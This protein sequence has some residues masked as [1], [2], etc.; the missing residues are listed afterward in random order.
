MGISTTDRTARLNREGY[1]IAREVVSIALLQHLKSLCLQTPEQ[2]QS[3]RKGTSLYGVRHLLNAVPALHEIVR[4][5]P[6]IELA[7]SVLGESARPVKGIFF[8]KTPTANWLVPWHQDVTITVKKRRD[9]AGFE[10]RPVQGGIVHVLPPVSLSERLLTLRIHLDDAGA[11]HGALRVIPRSHLSGRLSPT[12]IRQWVDRVPEIP[13]SVA[14]GDVM[15][16]RPLLLHASSACLLPGHR[17]VV[18]IEYAGDDLPGG[19]E[20]AG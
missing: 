19:L 4:A 5:S 8:D 1:A 12:E 11:D 13:V 2:L 3:K 16:M 9:V 18:H 15:L 17:R 20:W 6:F 10:M 14:A 7:R